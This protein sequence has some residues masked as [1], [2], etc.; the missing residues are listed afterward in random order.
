MTSSGGPIDEAQFMRQVLMGTGTRDKMLQGG[1]DEDV[2]GEEEGDMSEMEIMIRT[3]KNEVFGLKVSRQLLLLI[4]IIEKDVQRR[5]YT[6]SL[7]VEPECRD[8]GSHG[9]QE[10]QLHG[11]SKKS[12]QQ[13]LTIRISCRTG[14]SAIEICQAVTKI[15]RK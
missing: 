3:I 5:R 2:S 9:G 1:E 8:Q 14:V 13:Q 4:I 12:V 7:K 6:E 15:R 11:H 10:R